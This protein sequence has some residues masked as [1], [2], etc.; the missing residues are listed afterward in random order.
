MLGTSMLKISNNVIIPAHEIDMQYIRAQGPGGQ[1][2]NKTSSAV[3]L[4]FDI[5]ASQA[6]PPF[7]KQR[8][9]QWSDHRITKG[10]TIIIKAQD[11][12]SQD[13][14]R[15]DALERLKTLILSATKTDKKRIATKPTY[16][17][18]QR[19][20]DSKSRSGQ[21]KKLRKKVNY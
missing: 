6:L 9:L 15:S 16:G 8:L 18:K 11:H 1:H 13:L 17:S 4:F 14:N 21:Q 12:R 3:Q 5:K 2:V 10:G 20:M 19:R 7:Y